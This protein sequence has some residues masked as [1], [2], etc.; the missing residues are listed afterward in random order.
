MPEKTPN[1]YVTFPQSRRTTRRNFLVQA[2]LAAGAMVVSSTSSPVVAIASP[3]RSEAAP[4]HPTVQPFQ[5]K[6]EPHRQRKSF[7]DLTEE[8]VRLLCRAVGYMRNGNGGTDSPKNKSLSVDDP[9]QWD[10]LV[11]AHARHCTESKAG[12]VDQVHWSWFFLPWHRAYLWFLER[13]IANVITTI[14]GE[15][16]SKFALP[17]WDWIVHKEIP[18][19]KMR[20]ASGTPSPLF[21]YD[22]T[23]ENMVKSDGLGFDNLA[24]WDGYRKPSL[25]QPTMDPSNERS[26]DSKEHIE[27]TILFMSPEYVR[28]LLK[29]DFEGFAGKAVPP[30]A[31]IPQNDG[32]GLLEQNPHNLGHDW[33]GSRLGKNREMGTLRY[34]ASDP[35]FFM[36]HANID[37]IWS[38]YQGVQPDPNAPWG[39]DK[40]LWGK[41]RYTFTDIDGS[42]VV[43]TVAD[44]VTS[45]T[46]VTYV[47]PASPSAETASL[48]FEARNPQQKALTANTIPLTQEANTLTTKP[49]TI[50]VKPMA[51]V[52]SLFSTLT[53]KQARPLSLLVIESGSVTYTGKFTLKVFVN[54]PDA[55]VSTSIHDPH[56][57]G[58]VRALDSE[59]R[60]NENGRDITHSF[61]ILIPPGNSN[62]YKIVRPGEAF[63]VTLVAVGPSAKD[64][65]FRIPVKS[66]K[67]K[68]FE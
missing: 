24:L 20:A 46:N 25:A 18:N 32:M 9:L 10:N 17:Y 4:D 48:L 67:L 65:S 28:F 2:G 54:K 11:K 13:Q 27:E 6:N 15:D 21:G 22:L 59:G 30:E 61:S 57:I 62:F 7:H 68:V 35:I 8:E 43:V 51:E 29:L 38:W 12:V 66:I 5:F 19:T 50:S 52:K 31:P 56:Y 1:S 36:H 45:M 63:S 14:L 58:S 47:E 41:Q 23:K 37:R 44:I 60:T 49:L 34:A 55:D 64:E 40:Y 26:L 42:P 3:E 53:T 33:V 39:P 16:G